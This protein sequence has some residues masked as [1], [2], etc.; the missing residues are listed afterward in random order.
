MRDMRD[1]AL[2]MVEEG[3]ITADDMLMMCLKYM[4]VDE[5]EDMLDCNEILEQITVA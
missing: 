2:E 1:K 4:S 5:V 3:L